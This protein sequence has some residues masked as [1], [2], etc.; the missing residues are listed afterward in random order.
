MNVFVSELSFLL[1]SDLSH[2]LFGSLFLK[3]L[4]IIAQC[5]SPVSCSILVISLS[6]HVFSTLMSF[7]I[8]FSLSLGFSL[9]LFDWSNISL[10]LIQSV[11]HSIIE[12]LVELVVFVLIIVFLSLSVIDVFQMSLVHVILFIFLHL[13]DK[14]SIIQSILKIISV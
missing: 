4:V 10:M 9:F 11:F 2:K 13:F 8:S 7:K 3:N 12:I 14:L 6:S 5:V 1:S